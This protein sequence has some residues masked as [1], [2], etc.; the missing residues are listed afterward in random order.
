MA[1]QESSYLYLMVAA[2]VVAVVVTFATL[3]HALHDLQVFH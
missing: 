3:F 2:L 1:T